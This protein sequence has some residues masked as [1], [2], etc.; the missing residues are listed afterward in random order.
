MG[1]NYP[2]SIFVW[3]VHEAHPLQRVGEGG[4]RG[5]HLRQPPDTLDRVA[6]PVA[7]AYAILTGREGGGPQE[8]VQKSKCGPPLARNSLVDPKA[9][10]LDHSNRSGQKIGEARGL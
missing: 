10:L 9:K 4:A 8:G 2:T 5:A 1:N 6:S 3:L 7:V